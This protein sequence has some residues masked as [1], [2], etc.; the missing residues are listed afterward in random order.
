MKKSIDIRNEQIKQIDQAIKTKSMNSIN[1]EDED[2]KKSSYESPQPTTNRLQLPLVLPTSEKVSEKELVSG[3]QNS[4]E[5]GL[6]HLV[7][8][9]TNQSLNINTKLNQPLDN[10]IKEAKILSE[11]IDIEN[12]KL[13][14]NYQPL[15]RRNIQRFKVYA[16]N[17]RGKTKFQNYEEKILNSS[18]NRIIVSNTM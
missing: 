18:R 15:D 4:S 9:F 1:K 13:K 6:N 5:K 10:M 7:A 12:I 16:Q 14:K 17:H 2:N 8:K 11:Q 3:T